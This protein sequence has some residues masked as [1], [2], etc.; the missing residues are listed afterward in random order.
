MYISFE[1][2]NELNDTQIR[3]EPSKLEIE[4]AAVSVH[5]QR[6]ARFNKQLNLKKK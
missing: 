1:K 4:R 6:K 3:K 5:G 2:S